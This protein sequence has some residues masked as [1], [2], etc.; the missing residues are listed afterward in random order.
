M[1]N[2]N[3]GGIWANPT[4]INFLTFKFLCY[5][6]H[7]DI[8]FG[9]TTPAVY[10]AWKI[11]NKFVFLVTSFIS[12]GANRFD[13]NFLCTQRK[14]IST[15]FTISPKAYILH[16]I[17]EINPTNFLDVFDLTPTCKD[18]FQLGEVIAHLIKLW[19]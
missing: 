5:Y 4:S 7:T 13:L 9:N 1:D 19:L 16:G 15:A 2:L 17:P 11:P 18:F 12:I 6:L 3:L 14:F 8:G 10:T